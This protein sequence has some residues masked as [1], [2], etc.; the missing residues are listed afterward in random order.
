MA[1]T[2]QVEATHT[3]QLASQA[4]LLR[5]PPEALRAEALR[6][7]PFPPELFPLELL[8]PPLCSPS[9]PSSLPFSP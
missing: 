5:F 3:H 6:A 8:Q 2:K 1:Q 7:V 9:S 4:L